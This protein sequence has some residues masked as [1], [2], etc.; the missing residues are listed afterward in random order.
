MEGTDEEDYEHLQLSLEEAFF[1]VFAVECLTISTP[2]TGPNA[3]DYL[4]NRDSTRARGMSIQECWLRF[5]EAS[6]VLALNQELSLSTRDFDLTPGNRFVVRYVVY[7]YY[8][9]QGWIV[10]DGLKYGTDFL[11]YKKGLVFGHSQYAVRIIP[12]NAESDIGGEAAQD[13]K[14]SFGAGTALRPSSSSF[15]SPSPGMCVP[16]AV[17][18]WQ[19]LLTLNRVIAQVQKVRLCFFY[20]GW[21]KED[22]FIAF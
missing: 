6:S 18:S 17:Y 22:R 11:L 3:A 9:S 8:R 13:A 14:G 20:E 5:A 12:C 19:W 7:H 16:H 15:I 4:T 10:K 1:L 21:G 2:A